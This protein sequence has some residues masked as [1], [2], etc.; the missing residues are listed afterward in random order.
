MKCKFDIDFKRPTTLLNFKRPTIST[1]LKRNTIFINRLI[2]RWLIEKQ[3]K[4]I[5]I[6]RI[7][8]KIV[9]VNVPVPFDFVILQN[10]YLPTKGE[11]F[12][13]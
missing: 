13:N 12:L 11:Y 7:K 1:E 9:R 5:F 6:D 4:K 8:Y 2:S 3:T 10:D